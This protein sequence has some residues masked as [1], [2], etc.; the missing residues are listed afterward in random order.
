[1]HN[2]AAAHAPAHHVP[3]P[4]YSNPSALYGTLPSIR[5]L[6]L[7]IQPQP[8]SQQQPAREQPVQN[9]PTYAQRPQYAQQSAAPVMRQDQW[10][11]TSMS[12][13]PQQA[14]PHSQLP[15][16]HGAPQYHAP[17]PLT[18]ESAAIQRNPY[19]RN[20]PYSEQPPLKR[21]RSSSR[22]GHVCA[23]P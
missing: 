22:S 21:P 7:G 5:D 4:H 15:P 11:R 3:P 1:M 23:L 17:V 6:D 13:G 20:G 19:E 12:A 9:S 10:T 18:S 14:S 16:H 2:M 8:Q